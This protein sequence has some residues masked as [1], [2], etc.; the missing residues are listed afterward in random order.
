MP[1]YYTPCLGKVYCILQYDRHFMLCLKKV[2]NSLDS[3]DSIQCLRLTQICRRKNSYW[4][5]NMTMH[6][7]FKKSVNTHTDVYWPNGGS[8]ALSGKWSIWICLTCMHMYCHSLCCC[9]GC[10]PMIFGTMVA[11][12]HI[13]YTRGSCSSMNVFFFF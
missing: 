1:R 6:S 5:Q 12:Y 9:I 13:D 2:T 8:R 11:P 10:F 3:I 4:S 7:K